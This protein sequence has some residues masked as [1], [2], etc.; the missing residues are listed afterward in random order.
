MYTTKTDVM[1]KIS[2]NMRAAREAYKKYTEQSWNTAVTNRRHGQPIPK[3]GVF[4]DDD[5]RL[6]FNVELDALRRDTELTISEY[7]K[8]LSKLSAKQPSEEAVRAVQMFSMMDPGMM[9]R[10]EYGQRINDMIAEYGDN[11]LTYDTLRSLA[12]KGGVV[13]IAK[14]P[15]ME[16]RKALESVETSVHGF[17]ARNK[18]TA[19]ERETGLTDGAISWMEMQMND[20]LGVIGD[21]ST[22]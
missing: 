22:V 10:E 19:N 6:A 3:K 9:S 1:S 18:A 14:N 12:V 17:F 13:S 7:A 20:A 15:T 5:N 21:D 8:G 4:Y 11:P 2:A 16:A